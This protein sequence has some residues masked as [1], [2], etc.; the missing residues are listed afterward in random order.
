MMMDMEMES[1][2]KSLFAQELQKALDHSRIDV[3]DVAEQ[4]HRYGHSVSMKTLSYWRQGYFLP[5]HGDAFRLVETLE[6][7]FG[8]KNSCLCDALVEDLS[9]GK[10]FL[11][12]K[13]RETRRTLTPR[14]VGDYREKYL[15][16]SDNRTDW[17]EE[18]IREVIHD[19]ITVNAE[20]NYVRH[21]TTIF[22]RMPDSGV[23]FLNF[24]IIYENEEEKPDPEKVIYDIQGAKIVEQ[25]MYEEDG[26]FNVSTRFALFDESASG[27]LSRVSFV[28]DFRAPDVFTRVAERFFAFPLAFYSCSVFFEGDVPDSIE[29]VF[30][31]P[32]EGSETEKDVTV[33]PLTPIGNTVRIS[34]GNVF[35]GIGY[36][37]WE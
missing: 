13:Y 23:A 12:E 6:K 22:G 28:S 34:R 17:E 1:K 11:P 30:S 2:T 5:R 10:A 21:R 9:S 27:A 15:E 32:Q 4:L 31:M 7:I 19:A 35:N 29:Y 20:R 24:P 3:Q 26:L 8:I 37:R 33:T 36:V 25:N 14:K 18:I 16:V